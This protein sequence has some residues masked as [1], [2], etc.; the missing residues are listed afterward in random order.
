MQ[1]VYKFFLQKKVL[2][3]QIILLVLFI[4]F[5]AS[6]SV[7]CMARKSCPYLYSE[8]LYKNGQHFSDIWNFEIRT[9]IL[10]MTP[11]GYSNKTI[12][13]LWCCV[14]SQASYRIRPDQGA[15]LG[16]GSGFWISR[17]K[18]TLTILAVFS[19]QSDDIVL[20]LIKLT[21]IS[22][23]NRIGWILSGKS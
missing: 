5:K 4:P 14:P 12:G 2:R 8:S 20:I 16:S 21:L 9:A 13:D 23:E 10:N 22:K 6:N 11:E 17:L 7:Y 19:D 18:I 15:W 3:T 1:A